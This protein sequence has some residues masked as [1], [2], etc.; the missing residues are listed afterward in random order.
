LSST[1]QLTDQQVLAAVDAMKAAALGG[2]GG[3]AG[4]RTAEE[5]ARMIEEVSWNKASHYPLLVQ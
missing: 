3:G 5:E 4:G 2:A 1:D